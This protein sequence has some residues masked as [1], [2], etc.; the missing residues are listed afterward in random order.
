MSQLERTHSSLTQ[1]IKKLLED[2]GKIIV[3]VVAYPELKDLYASWV[4]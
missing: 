3:D 2:K 1:E 4:I